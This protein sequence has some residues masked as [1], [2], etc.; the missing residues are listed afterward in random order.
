MDPVIKVNSL[1]D[2]QFALLYHD[3][4][5]PRSF[6]NSHRVALP[7]PS[8]TVDFSGT[9]IRITER[10]LKS[11]PCLSPES[12]MLLVNLFPLFR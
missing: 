5:L 6:E 9:K 7:K 1:S 4:D 10:G 12:V 3:I 2:T 8:N 11:G